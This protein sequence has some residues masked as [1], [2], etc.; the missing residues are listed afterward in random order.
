MLIKKIFDHLSIIEKKPTLSQKLEELNK[1]LQHPEER[2]LVKEIF[3]YTYSTHRKYYVRLE[4]KDYPEDYKPQSPHEESLD[5]TWKRFKELLEE[6]QRIRRRSTQT[7]KMMKNFLDSIPDERYVKWFIR[8]VNRDLK[9]GI[10]ED[11]IKKLFTGIVKTPPLMLA[12]IYTPKTNLPEEVYIEP[13]YD[14]VRL[15]IIIQN[16]TATVVTRNGKRIE[17]LETL[18]DDTCEVPDGLYDG[19][20]FVKNWNETLSIVSGAKPATNLKC[21]IFEYFPLKEWEEKRC[22]LTYTE[23]RRRLINVFK[24]VKCKF[25]ELTPSVLV[26]T[27]EDIYKW[28][29]R[30]VKQGYEGAMI[31]LPSGKY[32]FGK[33]TNDWLKLKEKEIRAYKIIGVERGKGKYENVLGAFI[34]ESKREGTTFKVGGGFTDQ[35]RK[36]FWERRNELIGQC[37]EVILFPSQQKQSKAQFPVFY[38]LRP[39]LGGK[40]DG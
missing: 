1:L 16:K 12:N 27:K 35:Q 36:E 40:C 14:G 17:H 9:I 29:E 15:A 10:G 11:T 8:I 7:L 19:E 13:K 2:K 28:L 33:R 30:Y 4:K 21:Y 37:V 18:I 20:A 22:D 32:H 5:T 26:S 39:D 25:L 38:R 23:R 6:L 31:K 24:H 3:D 34:V